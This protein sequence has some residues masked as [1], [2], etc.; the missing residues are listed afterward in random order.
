MEE[1][2]KLGEILL[3]AG[4]IDK[5]QLK[6]ALAEQN[7]WGG[8]LG[9]HLVQMGILT[10]ELLVKALSKQLKIPY[11]DLGQMEITKE[12]LDLV[13]QELAEKFHLVPVAVKKIANKKTLIVAMS[14]PTNLDAIDELQFRTGHIIKPAVDGDTAIEMAIRKYYYGET[15]PMQ[16]PGQPIDFD[17]AGAAAPANTNNVPTSDVHSP[18]EETFSFGEEQTVP[19]P[20]AEASLADLG[21]E[22]VPTP[23]DAAPEVPAQYT[24][25]M[26]YAESLDAMP[27]PYDPQPAFEPTAPIEE[28]APWHEPAPAYDENGQPIDGAAPAPDAAQYDAPAEAAYDPTQYDANGQ[29]LYADV[30]PAVY[31]EPVAPEFA[32]QPAYDAASS[33]QYDANGQ[34]VY[35]GPEATEWEA[36]AEPTAAPTHD[37]NGVPYETATAW[38]PNAQNWD[39]NAAAAADP[40]AAAT[41]A[42][43]WDAPAAEIPDA[44]LGADSAAALEGIDP[45]AAEPTVSDGSVY[46]PTVAAETWNGD[47]A[48]VEPAA[49]I[50]PETGAGLAA[51][52]ADP[53]P[54]PPLQEIAPDAPPAWEGGDGAVDA[55]AWSDPTQPEYET[56][57][58]AADGTAPAG[59]ETSIESSYPQGAAPVEPGPAE[60]AV[61]VAGSTEWNAGDAVRTDF[62]EQPPEPYE[63]TAPGE[64]THAG[65]PA[66]AEALAADGGAQEA[67]RWDPTA[68]T[69]PDAIV[70][71]EAEAL[72]APEPEDPLTLVPFES[73]EGRAIRAIAGLMIEKGLLTPEELAAR[74]KL[75]LGDGSQTPQ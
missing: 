67:P 70:A 49:T 9:N 48:T 27:A 43:A 36:P 14:D 7:K 10:E 61:D 28:P 53:E 20:V 45:A 60:A 63:P 21:A 65:E 37:E 17:P 18:P 71:P 15:G 16:K 52:A 68:G 8:R 26:A 42:A 32:A 29:P 1:K 3:E 19:E 62:G 24:D 59:A 72:A 25:P 39:E 74:L 46:D 13:P 69:Q 30:A 22:L 38:D 5:F 56:A 57:P 31:E 54:P 55:P 12:T 33:T 2:K 11:L 41:A 50:D 4:V 23:L 6:S 34:P 75:F 64:P 51:V 58:V 73:L 66:T 35:G 44:S 47:A 40:N